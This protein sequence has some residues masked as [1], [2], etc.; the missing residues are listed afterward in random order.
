MKSKLLIASFLAAAM[1]TAGANTHPAASDTGNS[2][3]D[4]T[5]VALPG[6][7]ECLYG[8]KAIK[9]GDTLIVSGSNTVLVCASGTRGPVFYSLAPEAVKRVI[10]AST[11]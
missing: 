10:A 7:G 1:A 5:A 6:T 4:A 2:A 8:D 3:P 9:L 11:K